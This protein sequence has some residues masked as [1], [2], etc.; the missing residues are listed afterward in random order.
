M[1][2]ALPSALGEAQVRRFCGCCCPF[3]GRS[4]GS[5]P[6]V[7]DHLQ[8]CQAELTGQ[9]WASGHALTVV[10]TELG[11]VLFDSKLTLFSGVGTFSL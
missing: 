11:G 8:M 4:S 9:G 5:G 7:E 2:A 6:A 1:S 10:N 3:Q